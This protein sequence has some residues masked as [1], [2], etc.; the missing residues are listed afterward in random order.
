MYVC[1]CTCKGCVCI[2][3]SGMQN[4]SLGNSTVH[5]WLLKLAL[6]FSSSSWGGGGRD[7]YHVVSLSLSWGCFW[8]INRASVE[9]AN[10]TA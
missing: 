6:A 10:T 7:S 5:P 1:L 2:F 8:R 4:I 3:H 9:K